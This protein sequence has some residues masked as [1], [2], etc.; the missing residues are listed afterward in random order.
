MMI[1][2]CNTA[3][4]ST[5]NALRKKYSLPI[6][7]TIPALKPAAQHTASGIIAVLSTPSTSKSLTLKKLIK[8]NCKGVNV[9][10]IGCKGLASV[11]EGDIG[12]M[13]GKQLLEKYLQKVK[14]SKADYLVLGCTQYPFLK[15]TIQKI[16]GSHVKL[17]D[18]GKAIAKYTK[19]LLIAKN[20]TNKEKR[21]RKT[22][23]FTTG[24]AVKFSRVA[25]KLL[26]HKIQ[27]KK[28]R[29]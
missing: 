18:S 23:Y 15:K 6:V 26:K 1:V 16:V 3:T 24:N 13:D 11:V 19:S 14:N 27:T 8:D 29:V 17:L 9:L 25:T 5:I 10:N 22:L 21:H 28:I 12:I 20:I 2:A 7:G 4:A